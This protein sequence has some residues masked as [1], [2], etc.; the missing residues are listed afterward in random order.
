MG[1]NTHDP[2]DDAPAGVD[3]IPSLMLAIAYAAVVGLLVYS[4]LGCGGDM[5]AAGGLII[6]GLTLPVSLLVTQVSPKLEIPV[7][8]V[9]VLVNSALIF[10]VA[11]MIANRT[12]NL[13]IWGVLALV[14]ASYLLSGCTDR[15]KWTEQVRLPDGRVVK[16]ERYQEFDGPATYPYGPPTQS[17]SG[18]EFRMPGTGGK[19]RWK[20]KGELATVAL[21]IDNSVSTLLTTPRTGTSLRHFRCSSPPYLAFQYQ[22][23]NWAR[24]SLNDV[25]RQDRHPN[26]TGW[27]VDEVRP[28]IVASG[29]FLT[30][31]MVESHRWHQFPWADDRPDGPRPAGI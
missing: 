12:S 18:F 21:A 26:L 17:E 9:A 1:D 4:A 31:E 8:V 27:G 5:C 3:P 15:L 14:A 22:D 10:Y 19:V 23:G 20:D 6:M 24:I 2:A 16:L 25:P 29:R 13:V 28:V 7:I 11:R 30:T